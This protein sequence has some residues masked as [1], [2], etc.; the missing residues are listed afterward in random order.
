MSFVV[1]SRDATRSSKVSIVCASA[2]LQ[3]RRGVKLTH[4]PK[5]TL[6]DN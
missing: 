4:Y 2:R 6:I 1:A 5:S 3:F